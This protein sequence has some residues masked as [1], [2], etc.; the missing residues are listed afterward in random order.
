MVGAP[1][2]SSMC[3][4][5]DYLAPMTNGCQTLCFASFRLQPRPSTPTS[6]IPVSPT[7]DPCTPE[8]CNHTY[9]G[10]GWGGAWGGISEGDV[11]RA[12]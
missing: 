1:T 12:H 10:V 11:C 6:V 2:S 8:A 4:G 7:L 5:W 9:L 3:I